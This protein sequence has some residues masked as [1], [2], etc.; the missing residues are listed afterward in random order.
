MREDRV[1][2]MSNNNENQRKNIMIG[3]HLSVVQEDSKEDM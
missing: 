2:Q 3:Q 1:M